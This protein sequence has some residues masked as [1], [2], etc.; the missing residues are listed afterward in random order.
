MRKILAALA[1]TLG[2]FAFA[3]RPTPVE[4]GVQYSARGLAPYVYITR[5]FYV[6]RALGADLWVS[7][8]AEVVLY[9]EDADI[10]GFAQVQFLADWEPFTLDIYGGVRQYG[11]GPAEW[12]MRA[13]ILFEL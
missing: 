2:A 4:V 10:D 9:W 12:Y 3:N 13:G 6:G 5:D 8:S 1:L 11:T 7:P